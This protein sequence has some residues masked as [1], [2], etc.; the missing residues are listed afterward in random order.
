METQSSAGTKAI[1]IIGEKEIALNSVKIRWMSSG[2]EAIVPLN[3]L[4]NALSK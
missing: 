2:E 1:V 4:K 3:E